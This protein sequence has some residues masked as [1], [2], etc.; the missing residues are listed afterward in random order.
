MSTYSGRQ[1]K[2]AVKTDNTVAYTDAAQVQSISIDYEGN[3]ENIYMLGD[4]NPQE[5]KEGTIAISG[6][7]ERNFVTGNFS[8]AGTTFMMLAATNPPA[9]MWVALFPGGSA[10]PKILVSNCKFGGYSVSVD[11][12]GMV[13]ERATFS[14]KAIAVS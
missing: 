10:S 6:T 13:T 14:G 4:R 5:I 8:A 9:E 12:N 11:V 7:I 2:V 3:L 1:A